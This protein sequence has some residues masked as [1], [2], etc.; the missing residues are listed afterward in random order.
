MLAII[1]IIIT[2]ILWAELCP[3]STP[4]KFIRYVEVRILNN[5]S[6]FGDR[7][8]NKVNKVK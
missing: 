8:L 4:T 3:P 1:A 2:S 5:V 6:V 7:V